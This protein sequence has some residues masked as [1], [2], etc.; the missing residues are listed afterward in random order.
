MCLFESEWLLARAGLEIT[1]T[2]VGPDWRGVPDFLLTCV[3]H[4]LILTTAS[5][6]NRGIIINSIII[7]S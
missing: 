5:L 3:F 4:M 6:G 1:P 2:T 7:L